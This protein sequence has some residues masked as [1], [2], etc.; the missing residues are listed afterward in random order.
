MKK[1]F[2]PALGIPQ[3]K[4]QFE[5][6]VKSVGEKKA[7]A[8]W[9]EY[10]GSVPQVFFNTVPERDLNEILLQKEVTSSEIEDILDQFANN[11]TKRFNIPFKLLTENEAKKI[12]P[13][14][15]KEPAFFD[16]T[17]AYLVK[18]RANKTSAVHE[19][20]THPFLLQIEKTNVELYNNL[21]TAAKS[22]KKVT[23][24]IN[25]NYGI[26]FV[27]LES[28]ETNKDFEGTIV[29]FVERIETTK[30]VPVALRALRKEGRILGVKKLI[31]QKY[32]DKSWT[33]PVIL[34]DGSSASKLPADIFSSFNEFL[35][36]AFLHE[37]AHE[38][39]LIEEGET[40]GHYEDRVNNEALN[41]LG[42]SQLMFQKVANN[43]KT[44]FNN[45]LKEW[46]KTNGKYVEFGEDS[47]NRKYNELVKIFGNNVKRP[48][49]VGTVT[50][51]GS[52]M[53][54]IYVKKPQLES[55]GEFYTRWWKGLSNEEK[56][57]ETIRMENNSEKMDI[58]FQGGNRK[59]YYSQ[60]TLDHETIAAAID[61]EIQKEL[62]NTKD[63]NLRS[64]LVNFFNGLKSYLKELFNLK[65]IHSSKIDPRTTLQQLATYV[66]YAQGKMNLSEVTSSI[67]SLFN[68]N[69]NIYEF[70]NEQEAA[71]QV[72]DLKIKTGD[73]IKISGKLFSVK[74]T[75][76]EDIEFTSI[77]DIN[78]STVT[79][80]SAVTR[81]DLTKQNIGFGFFSEDPNINLTED[82]K[83]KQTIK[84][85]VFIE[86]H[87]DQYLKAVKLAK[88][89]KLPNVS[90]FDKE[91]LAKTFANT[92][93]EVIDKLAMAGNPKNAASAFR[94][95]TIKHN[96][97]VDKVAALKMAHSSSDVR[98]QVKD[99]M[100]A[101]QLVTMVVKEMLEQKSPEKTSTRILSAEDREHFNYVKDTI[102][103][104]TTNDYLQKLIEIANPLIK[105]LE[106]GII[107]TNNMTLVKQELSKEDIIL[108]DFVEGEIPAEIDEENLLEENWMTN[109]L[110]K[111]FIGNISA[112]IKNKFSKIVRRDISTDIAELNEF[113]GYDYYNSTDIYNTLIQ[114]IF[115]YNTVDEQLAAL[116][117]LKDVYKWIPD[118]L[119][120]IN[121]SPNFK[122]LF[123][124]NFKKD[125]VTYYK[126]WQ[127]KMT[128]NYKA[129]IVNKDG[130]FSKFKEDLLAISK[131]GALSLYSSIPVPKVEADKA[132]NYG[133]RVNDEAIQNLTAKLNE[134][135]AIEAAIAP[136]RVFTSVN[137]YKDFIL[138]STDSNGIIN[139]LLE[140]IR[141]VGITSID[142]ITLEKALFSGINIY[143][144]KQ[145]YKQTSNYEKIKN[146]LLNLLNTL[147][148]TNTDKYGALSNTNNAKDIQL[149]ESLFTLLNKYSEKPLEN[150]IYSNGAGYYSYASPNF[151]NRLINKL[152][153][154]TNRE[155]ITFIENEF[156]NTTMHGRFIDNKLSAFFDSWL[157][158]IYNEAKSQL[159]AGINSVKGSERSMLKFTTF[160][161][162]DKKEF[163]ELSD[164]E[165][166]ETAVFSYHNEAN[167]ELK[168]KAMYMLPILADKSVNGFITWKKY[169]GDNFD[170]VISNKLYS[171]FMQEVDRINSVKNRHARRNEEDYT[172]IEFYDIP[173]S[174]DKLLFRNGDRFLFLPMFQE[175]LEDIYNPNST[176]EVTKLLQK[177]LFKKD[178]APFD[179]LFDTEVKA[180]IIKKIN[181]G[182]DY[183]FRLWYNGLLAS[184]KAADLKKSLLKKEA[185]DTQFE[186]H[187][188]EFFYNNYYAQSQILQLT[189]GDLAFYPD[190]DAV[191]KR[192]AQLRAPGTQYDINAIN[193]FAQKVNG[194]FEK[195]TTDGIQKSLIIEDFKFPSPDINVIEDIYSSQYK[196]QYKA[197]TEKFKVLPTDSAAASKMKASIMSTVMNRIHFENEEKLK[198]Y[199]SKLNSTDGQSIIGINYIRK[200]EGTLGRWS[201]EKENIYNKIKT[202]L[203][204]KDLSLRNKELKSL[205]FNEFSVIFE[206]RKPFSYGLV[207]TPAM[208]GIYNSKG[209][210]MDIIR[211]V[212]T[213]NAEACAI[214]IYTMLKSNDNFTVEMVKFM[215]NT[216]ID[217][218]HTGSTVKTGKQG[219]L[220]VAGFTTPEFISHITNIVSDKN[221]MVYKHHV[222]EMPYENVMLQVETP[223]KF[224]NKL[225]EIGTQQSKIL[226]EGVDENTTINFHGEQVNGRTLERFYESLMAAKVSKS[227]TKLLNDL[228]ITPEII[229]ILNQGFNQFI[230]PTDP[231]VAKQRINFN[232]K[233]SKQLL[234]EMISNSRF[235]YDLVMAASLNEN[236]D[237]IVPLND[238]L[239]FDRIQQMLNAIIKS[240]ITKQKTHGAQLIQVSDGLRNGQIDVD[241]AL[242]VVWNYDANKK[243]TSLKHLECEL[244]AYKR[245]FYEDFI[246]EFGYLRTDWMPEELKNAVAYRIPTEGLCSM[247]PIKVV[248]FSNKINGGIIKLPA[249]ITSITGAD[250]DIDK[251]FIM[252][253]SITI[254]KELYKK[255]FKT[256]GLDKFKRGNKTYYE[257]IN[258]VINDPSISLTENYDIRQ[259]YQE[260][261]KANRKEDVAIVR[262]LFNNY[263]IAAELLDG[264]YTIN[265]I[266]DN[267]GEE[268][269]RNFLEDPNLEELLANQNDDLLNNTILNINLAVLTN[270]HN[271]FASINPSG[272][273]NLTRATDIISVIKAQDITL[274]SEGLESKRILFNNLNMKSNKELYDMRVKSEKQRNYLSFGTQVYIHQRN[275][276][277]QKLIGITANGNSSHAILQHYN[278]KLKT[279]HAASNPYAV[280]LDKLVLNGVALKDF[281]QY[282]EEDDSN[283]LQF[284]PVYD[285]TGVVKISNSIREFLAAAVDSAKNP[286]FE[287]SNV[288]KETINVIE[289]MLRLRLD[290]QSTMLLMNQPIIVELVTL[291]ARN[292]EGTTSLTEYIEEFINNKHLS[293]IMNDTDFNSNL[294]DVDMAEVIG[295]NYQQIVSDKQLLSNQ[296]QVLKFFISMAD[297]AK[298]LRVVNT[299]AK[300]DSLSA[301]AGPQMIDTISREQII[302]NFLN[303]VENGTSYFHKDIAL[304]ISDNINGNGNNPK[305][306]PLLASYYNN[307]KKVVKYLFGS[308]NPMYQDEFPR[309]LKQLQTGYDTV[310]SKSTIKKL[311]QDYSLF[312]LLWADPTNRTNSILTLNDIDK[313]TAYRMVIRGSKEATAYY[314]KELPG[315]LS[316][317]FKALTTLPQ[318]RNNAFVQYLRLSETTTDGKYPI[319]NIDSLGMDADEKQ[320]LIAGW[321]DL[322]LR[323]PIDLGDGYNSREFGLELIPYSLYRN[324]FAFG[325][326]SF[327]YLLSAEVKSKLPKYIK[328]LKEAHTH[329]LTDEQIYDFINLFK[330]HY[331]DNSYIVP[332]VEQSKLSKVAVSGEKTKEIYK[333]VVTNE[334]LG[335]VFSTKYYS[336]NYYYQLIGV[337]EYKD[338]CTYRYE[339]T[340]KLGLKEVG[341]EYTPDM[342]ASNSRKIQKSIY[343][344]NLNYSENLLS[345]DYEV[346]YENTDG[347]SVTSKE[348]NNLLDGNT[349]T[350]PSEETITS[351]EINKNV[352]TLLNKDALGDF[353]M[354]AS[355]EKTIKT[356]KKKTC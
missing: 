133:V 9:N 127:N 201:V 135:D 246:D 145:I 183:E 193:I 104:D 306:S 173:K 120:I 169:T 78:N 185:T 354:K 259:V 214:D 245:E 100:G 24:Y 91:K 311:Q 320:N 181:S 52:T 87:K 99:I 276:V 353:V 48:Y 116:E 180:V 233:L 62:D 128:K 340:S 34:G 224:E 49:P 81:E 20:F 25:K 95:T 178:G 26:P 71:L 232:I 260:L 167:A 22:S 138:G 70:P 303:R 347:L 174:S 151:I 111:S 106:D 318:F 69:E 222:L 280:A 321:N 12:A 117:K 28:L 166:I 352:D 207:A 217:I 240:K 332:K 109:Y 344:E 327:L 295:Y 195:F 335:T 231:E 59:K 8:L 257:L 90:S 285:Y 265:S 197:V 35:T 273:V 74:N 267:V 209:K 329:E 114:T 188:R 84:R 140:V 220:N 103:G 345:E 23:D 123:F 268:N 249:E 154:L 17:T 241:S 118:V 215:F 134:I 82:D 269:L 97:S 130:S 161:A 150:M 132:K 341:K 247:I 182:V 124:V 110:R 248:R 307:T 159:D 235:S 44:T 186:N 286:L 177:I 31:T 21:L 236:G 41:R 221:S 243:A 7:Y 5:S 293:E 219:V 89:N 29:D 119:K 55:I 65:E 262:G 2:C 149:Y 50:K 76:N 107:D 284:S 4:K 272:F 239:Q 165:L 13:Q 277:G 289:A 187:L 253:P 343:Q 342:L 158:E 115:K 37:K 263:T 45:L 300:Q 261:I 319:F 314:T 32:E 27:S 157:K 80:Q 163:S 83:Y 191:Q 229:A 122:T 92:F 141:E 160:L 10:Q 208:D 72:D 331:A 264:V 171:V 282:N 205:S 203:N 274:N 287:N 305:R 348:S 271:L 278:V 98:D 30:D 279:S 244:P 156:L 338:Y 322:I 211:G 301:A 216:D 223:S 176:D 175:S 94:S 93:S 148:E 3:V 294:N 333:S 75:E 308:I 228:G 297:V 323:E 147:K 291:F 73:I 242:R 199:N 206:T 61:L 113:G 6:L 283:Y 337:D 16:G 42:K 351:E 302:A 317:S 60:R 212:Q 102:I 152:N 1:I 298:D 129:K 328:Y 266:S 255:K 316:K 101:G 290:L 198:S 210:E 88:F 79:K 125:T 336:N 54:T 250:F 46:E 38:Y 56:L 213:K 190:V 356:N 192:L 275:F 155:L 77:E 136:K 315:R 36:F 137:S 310:V 256:K 144:T 234:N 254:D 172:P 19:I 202:I 355:T 313:E 204:I 309:V 292:S 66:L 40:R 349:S 33:N 325:N 63:K 164:I 86:E 108:P 312:K 251:L 350:K 47:A 153:G 179:E 105:K 252:F 330:R 58:L 237:F 227:T 200:T 324:G 238:E 142:R 230:N 299:I 270:D 57:S 96:L 131:A 196:K 85:T 39:I 143:D 51:T 168:N 67:S 121:D 112:E 139:T 126:V 14:Y 184:G 18:G 146:N 15:T 68:P 225:Q 64:Y 189:I 288:V 53:Y 162:N 11:L 258:E 334:F 194:Q 346:Y 339:E 43:N 170:T 226:F 281:M 218:I 304:L 296:V 326:R